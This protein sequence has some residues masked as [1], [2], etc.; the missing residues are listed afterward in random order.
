[1]HI[2]IHNNHLF[3]FKQVTLLLCC[4]KWT[5]PLAVAHAKICANAK[6]TLTKWSNEM[7]CFTEGLSWH[8][9]VR[10]VNYYLSC[11]IVFHISD[12]HGS[13][14][15]ARTLNVNKHRKC[16]WRRWWCSLVVCGKSVLGTHV[17][18]PLQ[19]IWL[20]RHCLL[21][22]SKCLCVGCLVCE[23]LYNHTLKYTKLRLSPEWSDLKGDRSSQ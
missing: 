8:R 2:Y 7:L 6:L 22:G 9:F 4:Y 11:L 23:A 3:S 16:W 20:L 13:L 15:S 1:M 17:V 19:T 5:Q 21:D 18:Y 10:N 14:S 12:S